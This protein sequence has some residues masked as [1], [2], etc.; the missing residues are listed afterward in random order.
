[1]IL[2]LLPSKV[3]LKKKYIYKTSLL[4]LFLF[5]LFLGCKPETFNERPIDLSSYQIEDGFELQAVV[6]EPLIEAPV[7][8][9]F[10]NQ[11]RMWV[12]EM[13]GY[14]RNLQGT[15]EEMPNGVIS[16]I[17]DHDKD[18]VADHSK[19][20]LDSL[21][22]PR[23]IAHV[24]GGLL[25]AEP[26]NLWFVTIEND[27]PGARV[28]VDSMYTDG[29]NVEHQ[30]NGLMMHLDNW[31][32]NAKSSSRYQRKG[33]KWIKEHTTFRGQWG[34]T[35]DNFGRLYYNTNSVQLI[36]DYVLPNATNKNPYFKGGGA[37]N[38]KMT[39]NQ[40]VFP[41]HPTSV[42]RGYVPGVL[43]KDSLLL[44][45]TSACGPL[46][47]T[48]ENFGAA[49]LENAFVCA[50][51]A[52]VVKRNILIFEPNKVSAK[53]AIP[54]HEFIA[55]TDE[56]FRPV[57]LNNGPDG[58]MYV[59]DM[60]RGILQDKVYLT[61]YLK[62]HY[63]EKKLDTIVGMGRVLRV[64]NK[65][66]KPNAIIDIEKLPISELVALLS[67]KNGWLRDRAQQL[68]IFKKN[69]E[70]IPL[71]EHLV[72]ETSN[73]IAKIHALHALDG[74]QA[75]RFNT[76]EKV[77]KLEQDS[78][79]INHALVLVEG[80]ATKSRLPIMLEIIN[81]LM[82]IN[83]PE[84]DLYLANTLNGWAQ[85][86]NKD[87]FPIFS[88]LSN[89]YV[90]ETLFQ[91]AIISSLRGIEEAYKVYLKQHKLD[92]SENKLNT[93]LEQ[94]LQNKHIEIEKAKLATKKK[95]ANILGHKIFKN[96][97]AACHGMN[98]EGVEALAPPL[99]NSEYISGNPKRLAL[100][101][102][103]GLA[104]PIY[105]NGKLYELNGTMPGLVNNPDF[106]DA[107]IQHIIE[108]LQSTFSKSSEGLTLE[109]IKALRDI[110][111]NEGGVYSEKELNGLGYK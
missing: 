101:L 29:G 36:G 24:Y 35:K 73:A 98:G 2:K 92:S 5:V 68:L 71:L 94:T 49:Y 64:V 105:V 96:I 58:T 76:L 32:Y 43:D 21:V 107:D 28:L 99:K 108:Y 33:G 12:V 44:K 66:Q 89:K 53:Q 61:N 50:P 86:S 56:G 20:F 54:A 97:C 41:L 27:K 40:R 65:N 37:E 38:I 111:P 93:I 80:H 34:I 103:H 13:K 51:E 46:I 47:Y 10:D 16:I 1:M 104:G 72:L 39:P 4:F 23:A 45:V 59:V 84:I 7:A 3:K 9:D 22:L 77:L 91:E 31:I 109:E 70:A 95:T 102:L 79:V 100:V 110:T 8:I 26:P 18:G 57:N 15:G 83:N 88:K 81:A 6:S 25:Y 42:N 69:K 19:I 60:H 67:H 74:M 106:T 55:S 30:P 82:Q 62:N 78:R 48:G 17:E 11:G 85:I 87:V 14:M 63:A 75:L 90:N 52:N